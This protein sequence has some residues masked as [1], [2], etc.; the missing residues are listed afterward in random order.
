M[1][2]TIAILSL[3]AVGMVGCANANKKTTAS[4]PTS[5]S[6]TDISAPAPAFTAAP[7]PAPMMA[8]AQP[9]AFESAPVAVAP[10]AST[11]G[12]YTVKKGDTLY[13]IARSHYGDGKAWNK[14][15]SANPGLTPQ[16]LKVG[17]KINLP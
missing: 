14:I 13:G 16:S 12:A 5:E 4:I 3:T 10:A 9:A 2:K 11:G 17:A 1:Y 15:T 7:A 8:A 6:V